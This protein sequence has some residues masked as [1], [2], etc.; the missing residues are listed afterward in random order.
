MNLRL[1]SDFD[2][3][4]SYG[5]FSVVPRS[6]VKPALPTPLGPRRAIVEQILTFTAPICQQEPGLNLSTL[7]GCTATNPAW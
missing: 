5:T 6:L 1:A 7:R 2:G 4:R 3:R